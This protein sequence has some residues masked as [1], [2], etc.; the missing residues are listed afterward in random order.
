MNTSKVIYTG[1]LRTECMHLQSNATIFTDAPKDNQGKGEAFSPT[2]LIATALASCV[3]TTIG[4]VAQRENFKS[5]DGATAEVI[6]VMYPE[7]RRIG[8]INILINFPKIDYSEKEKKVFE[9]AAHTCPIAKS[10]HPDLKQNIQ[11]I[12]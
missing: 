9:N 3:L 1:G 5:I 11:L 10:L 2:D 12:W 7:P 4:I 8:E 6:K